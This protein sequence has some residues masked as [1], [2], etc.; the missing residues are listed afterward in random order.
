[1]RLNDNFNFLL[2]W[3]KYY[4]MLFC[5]ASARPW[6][7]LAVEDAPQCMEWSIS[8][9]GLTMLLYKFMALLRL[10]MQC[11]VVYNR[12]T[13]PKQTKKPKKSHKPCSYTAVGK[14]VGR[15]GGYEDRQQ[16]ERLSGCR[17]RKSRKEDWMVWNDEYQM[18]TVGVGEGTAE[19]KTGWCE[20]MNIRWGQ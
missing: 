1:M 6:D 17:R 9:Y 11:R 13:K 3:I 8:R 18:G 5:A 2:G 16:M 19:R 7:C 4:V 14:Q 20:M 10:R 12:S 15:Q